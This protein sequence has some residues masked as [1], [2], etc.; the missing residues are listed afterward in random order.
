MAAAEPWALLLVPLP[1]RSQK[2]PTL[3][4]ARCRAGGDGHP[5]H[6]GG[7]QEDPD[8][9]GGALAGESW[10]RGHAQPVAPLR[11]QRLSRSRVPKGQQTP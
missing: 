2:S 11:R 3:P 9:S 8:R 10:E 7:D 5:L 4:P 6:P 1:Y